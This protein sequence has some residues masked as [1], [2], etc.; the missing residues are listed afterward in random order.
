M[1]QAVVSPCAKVSGSI[2]VPGDKS[3]SHRAAMMSSL[4]SGTSEISGFLR[5][6]DCLNTLKALET[7]GAVVKFSGDKIL[8]TGGKWHQPEAILDL[9]NSG[10]GLRLMAGLLAGRPWVS[11]LTGDESLRSRP[12]QRIK[13]PLEKMGALLE[14]TGPKG[15]APLRIKG[16][17][18]HAIDYQMPVASAQVKSCILL[19]ALFAEGVTTVIEKEKTRDHTERIFMQLGLP[20]TIEDNKLILHG[21]GPGG[22]ELPPAKWQ[23][24]GDFSSAAFWLAAAAAKPGSRVVI[25]RAGLNPRRTAF[26][27]VL[28]RMGAD[29]K[30]ETSEDGNAAEPFGDIIVN[31]A[32]LRRTE[33]GGE[34][35]PNI[36]DELPLVA[37]LG[38][39]ADG[40]TIIS[41]AHELRLK[42]SDR[43]AAMAVNLRLAGVELEEKEDGLVIY[44]GG[45]IRGNASVESRGDHRI[46]MAMTILALSAEEGI[47]IRNIA[48]VAT[49]YPSFWDHLRSIGAKV[50][51]S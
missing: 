25:R 38:A 41:G 47:T 15:C 4:A 3:V 27:N 36:I 6:E 26:L 28:R 13:E 8:V 34:E 19:A 44:G 33:V 35:I 51:I 48:C 40:R 14:L 1:E 12:M 50:R 18:L 37:V 10:T 2:V 39:L 5:A 17:K 31:G 16:A 20:L 46:A 23:V 30:V 29:I 49:S 43:I 9:G 11:E 22:P 32:R 24:P 42:E 21:F 45:K 7:L